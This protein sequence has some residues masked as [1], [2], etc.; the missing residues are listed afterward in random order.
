MTL[1]IDSESARS[2]VN[3]CSN[4]SSEISKSKNVRVLD[5]LSTSPDGFVTAKQIGDVYSTFMSEDLGTLLGGY[6]DQ[7]EAMA[8]LFAAAGGLIDAQ[9]A[10]AAAAIGKAA[11]PPPAMKSVVLGGSLASGVSLLT[12]TYS[13]AGGTSSY[14]QVGPEE[15]S[16]SSLEHL[17]TA[18]SA[19]DASHFESTNTQLTEVANTLREASTALKSGIENV[20]GESWTGQFAESATYSVGRF[21]ESAGQLADS[22]DTVASKA[23][24]AANGYTTTRDRV[25]T[26]AA[27]V[28]GVQGPGADS[29]A[30]D[31]AR[32]VVNTVYSPAVM[33]ANLANVDFPTAY[34][35]VSSSAVGGAQGIDPV[36][37]WNT[38]G[39]ITP[40][41]ASDGSSTGG[42]GGDTAGTGDAGGTGGGAGASAALAG[43]AAAG[44]AGAGA[45]AA[46]GRSSDS[47]TDSPDA[48]TRSAL[49]SGQ[50]GK[51]GESSQSSQGIGGAAGTGHG[52]AGTNAQTTS[53]SAPIYTAP[54]TGG[55]GGSTPGAG[56]RA[57]LHPAIRCASGR[58]GR[59]RPW[60]SFWPAMRRQSHP[61]AGST[62]RQNCCAPPATWRQAPAFSG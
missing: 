31:Q 16:G 20:L 39:T 55:T 62:R 51:D 45:S 59:H 61:S 54:L 7:A 33:R 10:Q 24:E 18:T 4:F 11:T 27:L 23:S 58:Q 34:R 12:D 52:A 1:S 15:V 43:G 21:A 17:V 3:A 32:S 19:L 40:A 41:S 49:V 46:L 14:A 42:A 35:V 9:D 50:Y 8:M 25:G 5:Q 26:E 60:R 47:A 6:V 13:P 36:R 29:G 57:G 53:A 56:A 22:L 2:C 44:G 30:A 38:D 28:K 37:A 48:A